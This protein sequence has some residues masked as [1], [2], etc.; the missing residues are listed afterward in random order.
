[1]EK[2]VI[3]ISVSPKSSRSRVAVDENNG[4]KVYLNSPP[5]DG[6]AN[7]ELVKL[8]SKKLGIA[9]SGIEITRGQSSRKKTLSITGLDKNQVI[10][11]LK[12]EKSA[13]GK[14]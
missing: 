14:K 4:I 3:D 12:G 1:M 9:K 5:A 7:A 11:K 2:A 13:G 10:E 6:K 8:L